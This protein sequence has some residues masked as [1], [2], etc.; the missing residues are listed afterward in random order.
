MCIYIYSIKKT[1]NIYV[2]SMLTCQQCMSGQQKVHDPVRESSV[3]LCQV[4]VTS[5]SP[6]HLC[7]RG[8]ALRL[9]SL[10]EQRARCCE[11]ESVTSIT[12][13]QSEPY[14]A[15]AAGLLLQP[16]GVN[17]R[18]RISRPACLIHHPFGLLVPS[19]FLTLSLSF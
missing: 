2:F 4:S 7:L 9:G 10:L 15:C 6:S 8:R 3:L 11:L 13:V 1:K 5:A 16:R 18:S 12:S 17:S 14:A 19:L